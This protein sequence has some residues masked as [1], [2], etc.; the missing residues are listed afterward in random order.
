MIDLRNVFINCCF[1]WI[2]IFKKAIIIFAIFRCKSIFTF[3]TINII[4]SKYYC[5]SKFK[6]I[7]EYCII[8][9]TISYGKNP[10]FTICIRGVFPW[11][12]IFM[13]KISI[14]LC[15]IF[16]K[17]IICWFIYLLYINNKVIIYLKSYV[18]LSDTAIFFI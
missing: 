16:R 2:T 4:A 15:F 7:L 10:F 12:C 11:N 1:Y 8:C 6:F 17:N 3:F 18:M 14:I 13:T 9:F 5:F